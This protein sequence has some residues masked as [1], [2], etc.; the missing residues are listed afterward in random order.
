MLQFGTDPLLELQMWH[1]RE[2]QLE[3]RAA[4]V[5][6]YARSTSGRGSLRDALLMRLGDALI[7]GGRWLKSRSPRPADLEL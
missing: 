4:L 5:T 2:R 1:A 3:R 6:A 7:A